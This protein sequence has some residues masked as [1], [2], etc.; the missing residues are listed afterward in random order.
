MTDLHFFLL[1]IVVG[2]LLIG[3]Y[4]AARSMMSAWWASVPA[5]E[6]EEY[7]KWMRERERR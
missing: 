1:G 4:L 5:W 7:E 2:W 6:R 3:L